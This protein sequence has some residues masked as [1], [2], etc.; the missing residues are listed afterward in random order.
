MNKHK[1]VTKCLFLKKHIMGFVGYLTGLWCF[2]CRDFAPLI[3]STLP[4]PPP[5]IGW[6]STYC[7]TDVCIGARV[8]VTPITKGIPAQI[9]LGGMFFV[10]QG[11]G[12]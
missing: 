5:P 12:F 2:Q 6:G 8:S 9:F 1:P 10:P 7:F 11:I 3:M 4:H